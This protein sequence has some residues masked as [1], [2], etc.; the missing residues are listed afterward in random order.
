MLSATLHPP[1]AIHL[2]G[3]D[4]LAVPVPRDLC[5]GGLHLDLELGPVVL[6]HGLPLE[7][8]RER[9][10]IFCAIKKIL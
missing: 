6:H 1:K 7:L 4:F 10:R 3:V 9:V 8:A 2:L 5:V